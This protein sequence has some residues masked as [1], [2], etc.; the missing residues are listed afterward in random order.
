MD[1]KDPPYARIAAEVRHRIETGELAPGSRVPS[2]REIT[3][4]WGVAMA[5]ATKA[6]AALRDQG[7]VRAVPGVGTV[8]AEG[9]SAAPSAP[10]RSLPP[11][12]GR[13]PA[14]TAG[15]RTAG[16]RT[17][18][19][20]ADAGAAGARGAGAAGGPAREIS[21]RIVA[22][23]IEVADA[24]G[25]SGVSMR[26][27]ATEIGVATMSLYR[28]VADK[29][30]LVVQMIDAVFGQWQLPADPPEG[31]RER[32]ELAGRTL[33]SMFRRHP[34]LAPAMSVTRPQPAPAAIPYAEWVLAA[35]DG[36]G[37]DLATRLTAHITLFGYVRGT[38]VNI[39][40]E[41]EAEAASGLGN[42]EWMDA[43]GPALR[44]IVASGNFPQLEQVFA[45][46]YDFD[47]DELFEFGLQR[48]LDGLAVLIEPP[49]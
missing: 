15:A 42:D 27:V 23:A 49:C 14:R 37:L 44:S 4:R 11:A 8:V 17:A 41:A 28:H 43:Q 5:T 30:D 38:A 1:Q 31:W 39:E 34:W 12:P 46:D 33:W 24:E 22:A 20:G 29:D 7:L 36:H 48:L 3:A 26:R 10:A 47:L 9:A 45:A 32:L 16:A 18:G 40:L 25:L 35:L 19:P 6:L 2:T 21:A 13:R